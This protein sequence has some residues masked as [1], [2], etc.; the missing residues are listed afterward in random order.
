MQSSLLCVCSYSLRMETDTLSI[1]KMEGGGGGDG[2]EKGQGA[3]AADQKHYTRH[4][5]HG[6]PAQRDPG[7][8]VRGRG[9]GEGKRKNRPRSISKESLSLL[10]PKV[11]R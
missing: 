1:K 8:V 9:G 5:R 7:A 11:A 10:P 6:T 2:R 3:L 4:L